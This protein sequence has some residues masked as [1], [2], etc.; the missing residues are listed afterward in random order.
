[1]ANHSLYIVLSPSPG[2]AKTVRA[3]YIYD[4]TAGKILG[5]LPFPATEQC[6][7]I[8]GGSLPFHTVDMNTFAFCCQLPTTR[9]IS[10]TLYNVLR[11]YENKKLIMTLLR[12]NTLIFALDGVT[13]FVGF[14]Y[15]FHF[16]RQSIYI[17][18]VLRFKTALKLVILKNTPHRLILKRV[19]SNAGHH[20]THLTTNPTIG[21]FL[22]RFHSP[23]THLNLGGFQYSCFS[24]KPFHVNTKNYA[25][26]HFH[27]EVHDLNEFHKHFRKYCVAVD[28]VYNVLLLRQFAK[29]KAGVVREVD[30]AVLAELDNR[31]LF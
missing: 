1:V 19:L 18:Y 26:D 29:K 23:Q 16:A 17:A 12:N 4:F 8:N 14:S 15:F 11:E 24:R 31:S 7:H 9:Q 22:G 27:I 5:R 6:L 28:H 30:I 21:I 3:V 25:V 13:T 20:Y 10:F 2:A